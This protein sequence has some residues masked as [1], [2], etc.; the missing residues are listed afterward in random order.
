MGPAWSA[1][2]IVIITIHGWAGPLLHITPE[3]N[4]AHTRQRL[5]LRTSATLFV[6]FNYQI[7]VGLNRL[8]IMRGQCVLN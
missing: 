6:L 5:R 7:R 8:M 4:L 3:P 1:V 2:D